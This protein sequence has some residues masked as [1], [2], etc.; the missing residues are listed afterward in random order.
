MIGASGDGHDLLS[1]LIAAYNEPH[2][3][4]HTE[5]HLRECLALFER[6]RSLAVEPAEVE[7]ALWF[8]DA[9]Y[10]TRA[11]D[12]E[13]RSA[14]WAAQELGRAGVD[15]GRISRVVD[16]IL[17]TRHSALPQGQD[18]ELLVDIDLAILGVDQSRFAEYERQVSEEYGWVPEA[19]FRHKRRE[20]LA[21]FLARDPIYNTPMLRDLLESRARF[22]LERSLQ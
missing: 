22:N 7:M 14:E 19:I 2:R 11:D 15:P 4:Y 12:N 20:I 21:G 3:K 16:L 17:A 6:H 18:Q 8:H 9:V 1:R 10:D 13:A 5:Q